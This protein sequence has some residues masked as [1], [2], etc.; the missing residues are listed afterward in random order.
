MEASRGLIRPRERALVRTK[1]SARRPK[2]ARRMVY[3][4]AAAAS[5]AFAGVEHQPDSSRARR[6]FQACAQCETTNR[7]NVPLRCGR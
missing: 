6:Q 2:G 4:L 5:Q 1:K 3:S 7:P